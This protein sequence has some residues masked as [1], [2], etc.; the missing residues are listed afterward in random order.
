MPPK[1]RFQ[2]QDIISAAYEL[3]RKKG[4]DAINARSVAGEIGCSTQPIFRV[5]ENMEQLKARVLEKAVQRF[6][7]FI[8]EN[9][10]C[11]ESPFKSLGMAYLLYATKEP[12]LFHMVFMRH[13][14]EKPAEV[15]AFNCRDLVIETLVKKS[16]F[17][18]EQAEAIHMHMWVYTYGL[19][20]MLATEQLSFTTDELSELLIMEYRAVVSALVCE[21]TKQILPPV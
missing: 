8:E 17:S 9:K 21:E 10:N 13:P 2:Q 20:A 3:A 11:C 1:V 4:L 19:A 18:K 7:D 15:Q 16:G 14:M 5:F 6:S 12:H